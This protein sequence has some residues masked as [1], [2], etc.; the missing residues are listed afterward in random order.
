[1]KIFEDEVPNID[2]HRCHNWRTLF[3][4]FT[5]LFAGGMVILGLLLA[6]VGVCALKHR[7]EIRSSSIS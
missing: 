3:R 6:G 1:M 7:H 5:Y 4:T 2:G